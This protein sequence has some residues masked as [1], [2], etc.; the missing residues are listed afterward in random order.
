M[1]NKLVLVC[2]NEGATIQTVMWQNDR[3][4]S[5]CKVISKR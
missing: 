1:C 5:P 3:P 4:Y 2:K